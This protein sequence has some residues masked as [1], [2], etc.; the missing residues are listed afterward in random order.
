MKKT[1][2]LAALAVLSL[3]SLVSC[4]EQNLG[5]MTAAVYYFKLVRVEWYVD[6]EVANI[7]ADFVA[8]LGNSS[9]TSFTTYYGN[10]DQQ[11]I[12]A[13]NAVRDKYSNLKTVYL[14]YVLYRE[15]VGGSSEVS[16]LA[17]YEFGDALKKNWVFYKYSSN[18]AEV[19]AD[20]DKVKHDESVMTRDQAILYSHGM[21]AIENDFKHLWEKQKDSDVFFTR[22]WPET[23][24][25]D[26]AVA[27]YGDRLYDDYYANP[28]YQTYLIWDDITYHIT[29]YDVITDENK[30][31]IW[32]KT[33]KKKRA[34]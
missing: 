2:L 4:Q 27:G 24:D 13:C 11:M 19:R 23:D 7:E 32:S 25:N 1:L 18:N 16:V 14:K 30:G 34:E 17:T 10:K 3:G 21:A 12:S 15:L 5:T 31:E 22:P 20:F 9:T 33:W 26:N 6:T 28:D 29:K 8:A